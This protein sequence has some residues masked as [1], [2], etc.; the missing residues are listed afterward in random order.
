MIL[1]NT[2]FS[3][4]GLMDLGLEQGGITVSQSFELDRTCCETLRK[5][6]AHEVVQCDLAEKLVAAEKACQVRVFTYPCTRYSTIGDIHGVRTGDDLYL[7]ALRHM[8]IDPPEIFV[9]EN[10]PGMRKFPV[11]ME[12]M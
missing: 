2:Y 10:V 4:A 12:V 7:H 9:A 11:V 5:N 8:V 3:G 1:T 6:F